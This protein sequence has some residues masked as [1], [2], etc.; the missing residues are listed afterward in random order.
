MSKRLSAFG[1]I[2]DIMPPRLCGGFLFVENT[3]RYDPTND[4][5][6]ER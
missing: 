3:G 5:G 4:Q 2:Y 1:D 6:V